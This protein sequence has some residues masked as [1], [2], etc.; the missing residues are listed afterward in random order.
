MSCFLSP[1]PSATDRYSSE[2]GLHIL[3][4]DE[5]VAERISEILTDHRVALER[6]PG[7]FIAVG[8]EHHSRIVALL[9]HVLTEQERRAVRVFSI[10]GR[11]FPNPRLLDEWWR[12]HE[13]AW[14]G[15]ALSENRF[16][17]WFQP[18]VDTSDHTV[19]GHECLIRLAWGRVYSGAEILDAA[20]VRDDMAA[21]DL[22]A[23]TLAIR[24]AA[25]QSLTHTW[26]VNFM[27]SVMSSPELC[28]K[29]TLQVVAESGLRSNS[30]VLE[31]DELELL[32]ETGRLERVLSLYRENGFRIAFDDFGANPGTLGLLSRLKPDYIKLNSALVRNIES[33][34]FG[35][36]VRKIA[37]I[38]ECHATGTIAKGVE[39]TRTMENLWLLGIQKMQGYL[40]GRPAPEMVKTLEPVVNPLLRTVSRPGHQTI[41]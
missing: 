40:F 25:R 19:I 3:A 34:L 5:V 27:P 36:T 8:P 17:T 26:F 7:G 15:K 37:D 11:S 31:L 41:H 23:R 16:S 18:V 30:I 2:P 1:H 13:T 20:W 28:L 4:A 35:A 12:V 21:F 6:T 29:N 33:P 38:A 9:R 22:H 14:F 32:D 24:S 39:T 10:D